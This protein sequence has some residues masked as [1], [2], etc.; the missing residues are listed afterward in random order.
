MAKDRLS[1]WVEE[2]NRKP[3]EQRQWPT[4]WGIRR[5]RQAE[6][7]LAASSAYNQLL[8]VLRKT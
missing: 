6:A 5:R 3:V 8:S 1:E 7:L 2:Q 4:W